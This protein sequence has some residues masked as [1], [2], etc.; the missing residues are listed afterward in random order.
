MNAR[1]TITPTVITRECTVYRFG[2]EGYRELLK[3]QE[4]LRESSIAGEGKDSI[5]FVQHHPVISIGASGG[6]QDILVT[7]TSLREN[8]IDVVHA[9]RG[10]K[11]TY[12]G[13]GQ[14][15]VYLIFDL[16]KRSRD[17]HLFVRDLEEVVIRTVDDFSISASRK[18]GYPGVWV[19]E[20]KICSIGIGVKRWVTKHGLAL[21]INNDLTPFSYINPC[22]INSNVTSMK[23]LLGRDLSVE[24]VAN[25][26]LS[27]FSELFN[28]DITF[29]PN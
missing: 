5:L 1:M 9:D 27:H 12:H 28:L 11:V 20:D 15:V 26:M 17:V 23:K 21:N 24:H 4:D 18:Q 25:V 6:I 13:P 3:L 7:D 2:L 22:G 8:D 10:G 14:L 19:S 29:K 16:R